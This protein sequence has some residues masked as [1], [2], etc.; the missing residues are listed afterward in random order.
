MFF[1]RCLKVIHQSGWGRRSR[2]RHYWFVLGGSA[3]NWQHECR[4]ASPVNA[5]WDSFHSHWHIDRLGAGTVF[6]TCKLAGVPHRL[7]FWGI[8]DR[9]W[10]GTA[11][12]RPSV[13]SISYWSSSINCSFYLESWINLIQEVSVVYSTC[14]SLLFVIVG[15]GFFVHFPRAKTYHRHSRCNLLKVEM[16]VSWYKETPARL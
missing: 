11:T 14:E 12:N 16:R 10:I 13:V 8:G 2:V 5:S 9:A 6:S 4:N 15:P 7:L 3:W 1:Q